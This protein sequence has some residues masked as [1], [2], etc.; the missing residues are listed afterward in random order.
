M[1]LKQIKMTKIL[2]ADD[3]LVVRAGVKII[4]SQAFDSLQ[5]EEA[6]DYEETKNKVQKT[7][8]ESLN[9]FMSQSK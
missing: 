2:I 1:N 6:L 4:L 9:T 7:A 3:H 8:M 5:I